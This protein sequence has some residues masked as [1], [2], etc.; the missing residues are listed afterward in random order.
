LKPLATLTF[1]GTSHS[2]YVGLGALILNIAV[3]AIATVILGVIL[4]GWS[5]V[6]AR[7]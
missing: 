4:P 2:F 6:T 5:R 7:S 1:N 3:G